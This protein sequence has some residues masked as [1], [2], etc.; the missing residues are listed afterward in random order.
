VGRIRCVEDKRV[1]NARTKPRGRKLSY[2][3]LDSIQEKAAHKPGERR[4]CLLNAASL[5]L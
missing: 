1:T 3:S 5:D 4:I 2:T